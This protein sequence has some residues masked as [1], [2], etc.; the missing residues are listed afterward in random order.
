MQEILFYMTM[1]TQFYILLSL[2][3]INGF[4]NYAQYFIGNDR[5]GAENLFSQLNGTK[6]PNESIA[7][8]IDFMETVEEL[9]VKVKTIAC[10]LNELSD[11]LRIITRELFRRYNLD[12][13]N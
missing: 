2:K 1:E 4:V 8:H 3:T 5:N 6:I 13:L 12:E 11:N 10:T 9:P 7:L